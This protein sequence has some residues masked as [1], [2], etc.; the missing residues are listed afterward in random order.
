MELYLLLFVYLLLLY[1][2]NTAFFP[3]KNISFTALLPFFILSALRDSSIGNDTMSYLSIFDRI[4]L[5][6]LDIQNTNFEIGYIKLNQL[7]A[8]FFTNIQSILVVTS[9]LIYLGYFF[10][11][12][13]N[14]E[15][16]IFSVFLFMSLGYFGNSM[17]V[18]RQQLAMSIIF[19]AWHYLNKN[20]IIIP[21]CLIIAASLF[22]NTALIFLLAI[23]IR[24][25]KVNKISLS[26]LFFITVIGYVAYQPLL[27]IFLKIFPM[28][29]SYLGSIYMAGGVRIA[30]VMNLFILI[31]ILL[32]G[33]IF[34]PDENSKDFTYSLWNTWTLYIM[35]SIGLTVLSFNFNLIAR[36]AEYF[37]VFSIVYI[38]LLIK[39]I[40]N[41]NLKI[42][43][44][45]SL[46][47]LGTMFFF[48][49]QVYRPEW[50]VIYPYKFYR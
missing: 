16:P 33:L 15:A 1:L 2:I 31:L 17:N 44:V 19:F 39:S 41:K 11:I 6:Q 46:M 18:I 22:H 38:P 32:A 50:N 12:K 42:L 4:K 3:E 48:F 49:I 5:G 28:Y 30:S 45:F 26:V 40:K 43:L 10:F 23:F 24:K 13:K 36:S 20:K 29:N 8:Y 21:V 34:K 37:S 47:M 9:I 14:S 27:Q 7:T 35:I 25:V